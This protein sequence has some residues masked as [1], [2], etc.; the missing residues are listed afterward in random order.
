MRSLLQLTSLPTND[1]GAARGYSKKNTTSLAR[2]GISPSSLLE[3]SFQNVQVYCMCLAKSTQPWLPPAPV[4]ALPIFMTSAT[5]TEKSL[6]TQQTEDG[7]N[8]FRTVELFLD[9]TRGDHGD[10]GPPP[11]GGKAAWLQVACAHVTI[12][13][14]WGFLNSFGFVSFSFYR[15][16]S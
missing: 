10:P 1:R 11:D 14:T 7:T 6:N 2:L 9:R 13:N 3:E 5:K 16:L 12:F 4:G 15:M 8:I